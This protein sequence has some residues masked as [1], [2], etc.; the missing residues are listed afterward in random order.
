MPLH[1]YCFSFFDVRNGQAVYASSYYGLE[2]QR[3]T[4]RDI[5]SA[6]QHAKVSTTATLLACTYLGHMT[7]QQFNA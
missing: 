2:A 5:L 6:K 7:Q 4:A 1:Y 3:V